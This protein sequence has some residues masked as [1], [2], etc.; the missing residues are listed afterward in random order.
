MLR[1][2]HF[3]PIR[4]RTELEPAFATAPGYKPPLWR[5]GEDPA[6]S[7]QPAMFQLAQQRG[8]L[9]AAEALLD[10][11]AFPPADN[12]ALM[13]GGARVYGVAPALG[14]CSAP[15]A[16]SHACAVTRPRTP[17]CRNPCRR[18]TVMRSLPGTCSSITS[19]ATCSARPLACG[20][21][22]FTISPL[23]F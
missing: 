15:R 20:S 9:Q 11:L 14:P 21:S 5:E 3:G 23:R 16:E 8:V 19:A 12:I 10:P 17:R 13:P 7:E 4:P 2:A 6:H 22:A 1:R 18:P